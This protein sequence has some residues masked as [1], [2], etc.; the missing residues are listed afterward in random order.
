[1]DQL[2][3]FPPATDRRMAEL[4]CHRT[5]GLPFLEVFFRHM[6]AHKESFESSRCRISRCAIQ[7]RTSELSVTGW[8]KIGLRRPRL[9]NIPSIILGCESLLIGNYLPD[10]Q[11]GLLP[12]SFREANNVQGV[13]TCANQKMEV[14]NCNEMCPVTPQKNLNFIISDLKTSKRC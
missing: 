7:Q 3:L 6:E 9:S 12:P 1:M 10:F 4:Y 2:T 11:R 5:Q 14:I 13:T 8:Q